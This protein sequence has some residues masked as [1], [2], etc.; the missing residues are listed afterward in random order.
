LDRQKTKARE[1][2]EK[3]GGEVGGGKRGRCLRGGKVV[4]TRSET[5]K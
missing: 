2:P 1:D 4:K 5:K 3:G